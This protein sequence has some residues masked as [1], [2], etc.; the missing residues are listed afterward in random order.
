MKSLMERVRT[1]PIYALISAAVM[2]LLVMPIAFAGAADGPKTA[3]SASVN[4][5]VKKLKRQVSQLQRQ[6]EDLS[7]QP[8]SQGPEGPQGAQGP[9]GPAT[10]PAGGDLTGSYPNPLIGPNAVGSTEL[11]DGE[12][13][14]PDIANDAV[15]TAQIAD[16]TIVS[17]DLRDFSVGSRELQT[18]SVGGS[19]LS[20]ATLAVSDGVTVN[21]GTPGT[22][23]SDAAWARS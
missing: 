1:K 8:G 3:V 9:P 22:R 16:S 19:E 21:A 20:N 11:L 14:T 4:K 15:R 6:V 10:G 23:W 17:T 13:G 5:Q 2:G 12:V 7:N 18:D